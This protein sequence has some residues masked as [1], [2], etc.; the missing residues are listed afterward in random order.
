[1]NGDNEAKDFAQLLVDYTEV[2]GRYK[3]SC[4]I[5]QISDAGA[6]ALAQA[7]HYNSMLKS[8]DMSTNSISDAGAVILA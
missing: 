6:V 8:L 1:M 3:Y 7:F 4:M 5:S 2:V